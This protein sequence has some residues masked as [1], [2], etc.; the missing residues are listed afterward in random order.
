MPRSET[1]K[2]RRGV[3]G[4]STARAIKKL[5]AVS[6][7]MRT[8]SSSGA[9]VIMTANAAQERIVAPST[10]SSSV[11]FEGEPRRVVSHRATH[12]AITAKSKRSRE[13]RTARD[14]SGANTK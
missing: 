8:K 2:V 6:A 11:T 12:N 4:V 14:G 5:A 3:E 9:V 7:G 10:M 13:R 1:T